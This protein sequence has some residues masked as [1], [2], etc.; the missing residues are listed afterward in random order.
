MKKVILSVLFLI[1]VI[2]YQVG[3]PVGG[4]HSQIFQVRRGE[5]S[6]AIAANLKRADLIRSPFMFKLYCRITGSNPKLRYG[7]YELT[8]SMSLGDI[9]SALK[10]Q[11]G[12]QQLVRVTIPEGWSIKKIKARLVEL[13]FCSDEEFDQFMATAKDRY[14][15]EFDFIKQLP[16]STLEG[17][18]YPDTYLFARGV[19]LDAIIRE[20]LMQFKTQIIPLYEKGPVPRDW[21]LHEALSMAAMI[22]KESRVPVEMTKISSVFHNRLK[23]PM[24]L[25]SDPTVI[26]ALG[27]PVK[28]IVYYKDL[29]VK[30]PYNTY[31]NMGLPIGPIASP[32]KQAF[33]AALNPDTTPYLFFV[34]NS[35]GTHSFT[36]TYAEHLEV[37]RRK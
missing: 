13:G 30:S 17:Y 2:S 19:S 33:L 10:H 32:G 6:S 18:L 26:Y 15:D 34:A 4:D 14:S 24:R 37:Q 5:S 29:E 7:V 28:T 31:R 20:M 23:I 8:P 25:A 21:S 16:I 9:V 27:E 35:D 36:K 11:K 3:I 1:V 22:E 12:A